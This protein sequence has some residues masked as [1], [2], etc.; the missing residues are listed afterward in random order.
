MLFEAD[1]VSRSDFIR[2]LV[3]MWFVSRSDL[4]S[5]KAAETGEVKEEID[6]EF[7]IPLHIIKEIEDEVRKKI[8]NK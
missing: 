3:R 4:E 8:K 7:G 6:L 1:F 5:C 2:H